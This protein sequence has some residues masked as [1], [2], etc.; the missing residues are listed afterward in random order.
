VLIGDSALF[1]LGITVPLPGVDDSRGAN[2]P[3]AAG[4]DITDNLDEAAD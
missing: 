4:G 2:P 3:G 1:S